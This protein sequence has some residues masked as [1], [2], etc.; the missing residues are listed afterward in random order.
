ME[1]RLGAKRR[2]RRSESKGG[3]KKGMGKGL[4]DLESTELSNVSCVCHT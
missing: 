2:I 1:D 4:G 3:G